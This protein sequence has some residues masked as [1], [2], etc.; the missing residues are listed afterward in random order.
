M[1]LFFLFLF[2]SVFVSILFVLT[3]VEYLHLEDAFMCL[4]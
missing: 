3:I 1:L 2:A 4:Y